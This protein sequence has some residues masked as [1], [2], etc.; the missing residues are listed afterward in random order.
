MVNVLFID[1][2]NPEERTQTEGV[3][4]ICWAKRKFV[5]ANNT[6]LDNTVYNEEPVHVLLMW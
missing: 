5:T 6:R 1:F 3:W 2:S 4:G